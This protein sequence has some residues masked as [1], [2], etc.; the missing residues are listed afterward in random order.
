V[1]TRKIAIATLITASVLCAGRNSIQPKRNE[2]QFQTSD[3]CLA[4]HNGLVTAS[5]ADVSIG[6]HWRAS[7]MGNSSR[8]PYWQGSVRREVTDHPE[9]QA[10]IE[11]EC[12]VC[13]MP[14]TRYEAKLR[15][16]EGEIFAH[17][18]INTDD[19]EQRQAADGVSCSVC[20][21]ITRE[22]FGTPESFNGGFV[23][24]GPGADGNRTEYGPFEIQKGR[25][26]IMRSSTEGYHPEEGKHI[27][28]SELCATCHTLITTALGAGGK[29]IGALPE[30]MPYPEWVHSDYRNKQSCQDCHMP[31]INGPVQ[32]A[33]V[34]GE[35]RDGARLHSFVGS[36]FFMLNLLNRYREELNVSALPPELSANAQATVEFLQAE[37]ATV[38]IEKVA[39]ES[40]S[41]RA[42]VVIRNKN[43]H[44]LPTAYP[45]RRV[46][47]H[48][49]VRDRDGRS[50]FESGALN[51]D[52]SIV[53]N[54]NDADPARFEPHYTEI[55]GADQVEI[56]ESI[57]GDEN[58]H[59]TTGLLTGVRYLKDNRLLPD[60]FDKQ[61]ADKDVAVIGDAFND[62][63]FTG[64]IHRIRYVASLGAA[65]GPFTIEAELW[66]QPIGFRWANNLKP[67]NRADE[68]R[69]F[70]TYFDSMQSSTAALLARSTVKTEPQAR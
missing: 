29:V 15:G 22:K 56:Y 2:P 27:R 19:P 51:P 59:V 13:H 10:H 70:N 69:R 18:P 49:V 8:D 64:G 14:I 68:P 7:M 57:I 38:A 25:I 43:G 37:A 1:R 16:K 40:G 26:T 5:G 3:R 20:H 58:G 31:K 62:P 24:H 28:E 47:L 45:S 53:G 48:F 33:R 42:D 60:G 6:F 12:S 46:W 55:R 67:Y 41:L 50:V 34:L 35:A 39:A 61:T 11:D 52:G 66:Y 32:I 54:D 44:K 65:A 17:L 36:N 4:C 21:Q 30:Q 23:V 9:S 63:G